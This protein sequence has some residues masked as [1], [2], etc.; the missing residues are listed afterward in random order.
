LVNLTTAEAFGGISV[1]AKTLHS[2]RVTGL[3][4][5]RESGDDWEVLGDDYHKHIPHHVLLSSTFPHLET[6][7]FSPSMCTVDLSCG[8][9]PLTHP[10]FLGECFLKKYDVERCV[11][12]SLQDG[13]FPTLRRLVLVQSPELDDKTYDELEQWCLVRDVDVD[14]Q[15]SLAWLYFCEPPTNYTNMGK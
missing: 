1:L 15:V 13:H 12:H 3:K 4:T 2:L 6:L 8:N 11:L 10:S 7:Q 5:S 9:G 14:V